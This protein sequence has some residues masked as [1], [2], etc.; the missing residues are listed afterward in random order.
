MPLL[1]T[2]MA[3][4]GNDVEKLEPQT[5]LVATQNSAAGLEASLAVP[6]EVKHKGTVWPGSSTPMCIYISVSPQLSTYIHTEVYI[7]ECSQRHYSS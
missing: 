2:R 7:H 4:V 6:Q 1:T 5:L 3:S